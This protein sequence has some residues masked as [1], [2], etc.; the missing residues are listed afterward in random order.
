MT[1]ERHVS[2]HAVRSHAGMGGCWA[3]GFYKCDTAPLKRRIKK[4][5]SN[6]S[7]PTPP[8]KQQTTPPPAPKTRLSQKPTK[9]NE[10]FA[11]AFDPAASRATIIPTTL[12]RG[13]EL[14]ARSER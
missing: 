7:T 11:K 3:K 5:S 2:K 13:E 8:A 6:S 10:S 4:V 12:K 1:L 9:W 14:R